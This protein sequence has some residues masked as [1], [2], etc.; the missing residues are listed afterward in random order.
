MALII[1][2]N[3]R[4]LNIGDGI[5]ILIGMKTRKI[6]LIFTLQEKKIISQCNYLLESSYAQMLIIF[7]YKK[8]GNR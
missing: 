7:C 1:K 6:L 3:Y 8:D 5:Y 4:E 2:P